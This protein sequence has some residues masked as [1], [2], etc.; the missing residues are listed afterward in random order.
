MNMSNFK[1]NNYKKVKQELEEIIESEKHKLEL[2]K[3]TSA[4]R[5]EEI[6]KRIER[7]P[8]LEKRLAE[9]KDELNR[10]VFLK[11][12]RITNQRDIY[13]LS[14]EI[15]KL[16][17]NNLNI[18]KEGKVLADKINLLSSVALQC[19]ICER[20]LTNPY[21]AMLLGEF[22]KLYNDKKIFY[23]DSL[24]TIKSNQKK[25][26]NFEDKIREA[27]MILLGKEESERQKKIITIEVEETKKITAELPKLYER[28]EYLE[29]ELKKQ[30]FAPLTQKM[31]KKINEETEDSPKF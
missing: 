27:D 15:K 29:K 6:N 10:L 16:E 5:I 19:P 12:E 26:K 9:I 28:K 3:A 17:K 11:K 2:E 20:K 31:L 24:K 8:V 18:E 14:R 21:K 25:I 1:K 4:S 7:I 13:A 30:S 22:R 23:K